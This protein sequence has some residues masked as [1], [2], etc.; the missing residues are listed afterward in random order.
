MIRKPC[1][2]V[3]ITNSVLFLCLRPALGP[4]RARSP[5]GGFRRGR[6]PGGRRT[7]SLLGWRRRPG[8]RHSGTCAAATSGSDTQQ[9]MSPGPG[10][11]LW[12]AP[13]HHLIVV[14]YFPLLTSP[15]QF[16][17]HDLPLKARAIYIE[18]TSNF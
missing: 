6:G 12:P 14:T 17:F 1:S 2:N 8:A 4:S 5:I 18:A 13:S 9:K 7:R 15:K 11:V 16:F 3:C 10:G